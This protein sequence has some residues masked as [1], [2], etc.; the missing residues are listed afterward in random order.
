MVHSDAFFFQAAKAILDGLQ[1]LHGLG[2]CHRDVKPGNFCASLA[3]SGRREGEG[4]VRLIDFG[5]FE[6]HAIRLPD[7]SAAEGHLTGFLHLILK[8]FAARLPAGGALRPPP[9]RECSA[10]AAADAN[11]SV[12]HWILEPQP[13]STASISR[14]QEYNCFVGTPDYASIWALRGGV[15]G[16]RDDIE[17]LGYSLLEMYLGR[18]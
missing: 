8:G 7:R 12:G 16:A 2:F 4:I 1:A 3:P 13:A 14:T 9:S 15:Q 11:S 18:W 6:S 17:S 10:G 5:R